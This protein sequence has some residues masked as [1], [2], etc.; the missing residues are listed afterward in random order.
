MP[1]PCIIRIFFLGMSG[2]I[3]FRGY[4]GPKKSN[5]CLRV[6]SWQSQCRYQE[7][8]AEQVSHVDSSKARKR[9]C[10]IRRER[11]FLK[12]SLCYSL[13][14]IETIPLKANHDQYEEVIAC[15]V[16]SPYVK[17]FYALSTL[18]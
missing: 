10:G 1:K 9:A 17:V 11:A 12:S 14:E 2:N 16:F 6:L 13:Q 4:V 8:S 15:S 18:I 3:F 5:P 7:K